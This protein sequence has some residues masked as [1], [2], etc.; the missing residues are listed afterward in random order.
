MTRL[1]IVDDEQVGREGLQAILQKSFPELAIEQAKNGRMAVE[2]ADSF[3]PDLILMDIKM[4]GMDGLQAAEII[5]EKYPHVKIVMVTA[6]DTFDYARRALKLGVKDYLL[7]PSKAGEI[8]KTVGR[9]LEQIGEEARER[10]RS[11]LREDALERVMPVIETDIVTQLL[12]DHVHEVHSDELVAWLG[13][14]ADSETFALSVLVPAGAEGA[15][16]AIRDRIRRDGAGWVG[17]LYGRQIPIIAFRDKNRPFR[18]QASELARTLLEAAGGHSREGWLIGVGNVCDSLARVRQSYREALIAIP[19]PSQPVRY[20]L[21]AEKP[22][23]GPGNSVLDLPDKRWEQHFFEQIRVGDWD[24]IRSETLDFL[25]QCESEGA[26]RLNAQQRV[27]ERLW[28]AS[29]VLAEMG[30]EIG[31]PTF[32]FQAQDYRQLRSETGAVLDRIKQAYAEHL[33]RIKPDTVRRIKQYIT[34][35]SH[36][37]ISLEAIGEKFELSPFYISKLFKEQ[38]GVNYI[39]FLTQCRIDKAKKLMSDPARS[40]KEITFEVGYHDP[41]YFSKVFKKMCDISPTEYRKALLGGAE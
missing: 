25:R 22:E 30:V 26:D 15:Y 6:Y 35:N 34:E 16:A 31:T 14:D 33:E 20:R 19:D 38:I 3:R 7:K 21:Y 5:G 41:N 37:D 36:E 11:R 9:V 28:V 10:E 18:V 23:R 24:G 32:S 27:L 17:A 29:R 2:L 13:A 39:D 4:P 40:L 12:F 8:K 1:L